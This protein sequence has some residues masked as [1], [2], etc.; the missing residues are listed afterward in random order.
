MTTLAGNL[1]LWRIIHQVLNSEPRQ[2]EALLLSRSRTPI[3]GTAMTLNNQLTLATAG[4]T[5]SDFAELNPAA[6]TRIT[7]LK[8]RM[9]ISAI[10]WKGCRSRREA[11]GYF[12]FRPWLL[13]ASWPP[14]FAQQVVDFT[15]QSCLGRFF[16]YGGEDAGSVASG[17]VPNNNS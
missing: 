6:L 2:F 10:F 15:F 3:S 13:C 7:G 9:E 17:E 5:S 4:H 14:C 12:T 1:S 16:D 8:L 11:R